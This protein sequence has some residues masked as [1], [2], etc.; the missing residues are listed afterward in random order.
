METR[1]AL[2]WSERS[3][4][5]TEYRE[6]CGN[7]CRRH[8]TPRKLSY[9]GGQSGTCHASDGL[10]AFSQCNTIQYGAPPTQYDYMYV[11]EPF[12]TMYVYVCISI[13]S[14]RFK[15][16]V[17][18][19]EIFLKLCQTNWKVS[20]INVNVVLDELPSQITFYTCLTINIWTQRRRRTS[21][22][23]YALRWHPHKMAG[24]HTNWR[25]KLS[26]L[27]WTPLAHWKALSK[28]YAMD[29]LSC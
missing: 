2:T 22:R 14:L 19:G 20:R 10:T 13:Y 17:T 6:A 24:F 1:R 21:T 11:S 15:M 8:A 29:T 12:L 3:A 27:L 23:F 16:K 9:A 25:Q 7:W 28:T 26:T 4:P 5:A 18:F